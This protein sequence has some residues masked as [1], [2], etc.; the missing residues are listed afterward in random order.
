MHDQSKILVKNRFHIQIY[1]HSTRPAAGPTQP[2]VLRSSLAFFLGGRA[3][4]SLASVSEA[5]MSGAI[6]PLDLHT[7][8][9]LPT[10]H[11]VGAGTVQSSVSQRPDRG[12]VPEP[13]INY[14]T[15]R[16]HKG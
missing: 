8:S 7:A 4:H 10:F 5:K 16:S 3:G 14:T 1:L 13:G 9:S 6:S 12:P 2:S 15:P 11:E